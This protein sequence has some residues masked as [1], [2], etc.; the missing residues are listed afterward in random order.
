MSKKV[1]CVLILLSALLAA[2]NFFVFLPC[3]VYFSNP[4]EFKWPMADILG[5]YSP[6]I[7]GILAVFAA[8]TLVACLKHRVLRGWAT[9]LAV[10]ALY[11]WAHGVFQFHEFGGI[12]GAEWSVDVSGTKRAVEALIILTLAALTAGFVWRKPVVASFFIAVL[13]AGQIAAAIMALSS[14]QP[15]YAGAPDAQMSEVAGFSKESNALIVLLDSLPSGI[16][17]DVMDDDRELARAFDGFVF[18]PDT[19]STAKSTYVSLPAIHSGEE[20][21]HGTSLLGYFQESVGKN[22]I[23]THLAGE[24]FR[25]TLVNMVMNQCPEGV[26]C[27]DEGAAMGGFRNTVSLDAM[28]LLDA[29][30]LRVAPLALAEKVYNGGAWRFQKRYFKS[31]TQSYILPLKS[32]AFLSSMIPE[33]TDHADA[34]TAKFLHLFSSHPPYIYSSDCRAS[35]TRLKATYENGFAHA[36]CALRLTV[37]LFQ[38]LKDHNLYDRTAIILLSDHGISEIRSENNAGHSIVGRKWDAFGSE[39]DVMAGANA[40]FAVKPPGA[41]GGIRKQAG[42]ISLIDT[43]ATLLDML[44]LPVWE[45][46]ISALKSP[47][48]RRRTF[49]SYVWENRFW[50]DDTALNMTRYTV[51][52]PVTDRSSWSPAPG[53]AD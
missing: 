12:D 35:G 1:Y 29:V 11:I 32:N 50:G 40:T 20:Y 16:F 36:R 14:Q 39:G 43:G 37:D 41:H 38:K 15:I 7:A 27:V 24:G 19:V 3:E 42:E 45:K 2:G 10:C 4:G 23:L 30:L 17:E 34:P 47:A 18:F 5:V 21:S 49:F 31:R 22:S 25:A 51:S 46:G 9:G 48:G 53:K 26:T 44:G 13:L 28:K 6:W 52:G 8:V 33:I